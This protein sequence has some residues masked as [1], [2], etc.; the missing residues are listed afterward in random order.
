MP[1]CA[2]CG[3]ELPEGARFCPACAAPVEPSPAVEER[4][5]ATVLFADLVGSTELGGSQDP[6]RTRALLNRFYDAMAE[7]IEQAGGTVE[8]FA[9][10][11]VM[12]AF[13]AP[14]AHED[15][16]ERALHTA[17]SMQR[18]LEELFAGELDLRIGINTGEVVVGRP[19]EGSSFVTGDAVNVAARLEQA[20]TSGEILAGERTVAAVS[21]AFE[22][23]EPTTVEAKGKPG[24]VDCRR[25]VRALSL[26][27]PRGVGGLRSAFLGR[28]NELEVLQATYRR[29]AG[30]GEPHLVTIMGDAGV[31][32]TRLVRELWTWLAGEAPQPLQR[33]GRC[34]PYGQV[35]YWALGEVLKEHLG[36]LESDAPEAARKRLGSREILGLALGLDVG[37]DLH[38][39]AAR[40]RL[41]EAWIEFLG[42]LVAEQPAVLLV[43]DLH[44]ADEELLDL[45][46]RMVREVHGPLFVVGTARPELLDRRPAWSG[47]RRNATVLW[48]EP[49]SP[50]HS[51]QMVEELLAAELPRRLRE[52]VVDRAEGN[53]F[54]VEELVATLIDQGVL[55]QTDGR[56]SAGELPAGFEIP[57][58]VHAVL[59][60]RIDLLGAADKAGLQAASVIGR[61]FWPGP[62]S[63]LV[64]GSEPDWAALEDRDFVR[65]RAGSSIAGEVEYAFKHT[66]T[67]EVAYGSLPKAQRARL[68]AAFADWL[69]QYGE[70]RDEHAPLL[71]HHYAEATRP[72]DADLAWTGRENEHEQ[73]R[74]KA[75]AWLHRAADLAVGRYEL[76]EALGLLHRALE[77][78]ERRAGR[79]EM[80][81]AIGRANAF[82]FDGE[83]FWTAM[84]QAIELCEDRRLTAELYSDLALE[85]L[86]RSGM[87]RRRPD[88][89]VVENWIERALELAEPGSKARARG[90]IARSLLEEVG[91][92]P[93]A[94]E[95]TELAEQLGDPELRVLAWIA[96]ADAAFSGGDYDGALGWASRAF[97]IVDEIRDPD[98]RAD[99][100]WM[101][102][103]PAVGRGRLR[104]GRRLA[105]AYDE[106]NAGLTPH[107]RVHGVAVLLEVEELGGG[108]GRVQELEARAEETIGKN[109]ETPCIRNPRSLLL[110]ALARLYD[111][112]EAE[113]R[114]L[115]E[116]ADDLGME[117]F[118]MILDGPR[119][120][121]A[122]ARGDLARVEQ[123]LAE[124]S[125]PSSIHT[126]FFLNS[127]A[128]WLDGLAAIGDR[129]RVEADALPLLK[130]N[131]YLEP[132]ALRALGFVREDES[133][134]EQAV[135]RF[136][137]MRLDWHA[138]E[139]RKLFA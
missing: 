90:L 127:T 38:P 117:G 104:E 12:A 48:L 70:G 64:G 17:L 72:Q 62:V 39:L 3:A 126:T 136:E 4:K 33:T 125:K 30:Q 108:W 102:I 107:H 6:E 26:M 55:Q 105:R 46:E 77:L 133:L 51:A 67:R 79:A 81:H 37:G 15:H 61:T 87:W 76:D 10:D 92:A 98:L 93:I 94:A 11:A 115:E 73:L 60:A 59:A 13:G 85:T 49:L 132:F 53:P 9:G 57:D 113:A 28:D 119:L 122:L 130:P 121:L 89:S 31:G 131:T 52:V 23:G 32:K 83:A 138:A 35:T 71:A 50:E 88:D 116:Q 42:E 22:F 106:A 134:L 21:G 84:Q 47:G 129:Q 44:W 5:L 80:W 137:A 16:A 91:S 2:Q 45:L 68:H 103:L 99:I 14:D 118:G 19:R 120:R 25:V 20:A 36:I 97:E 1:A 139:T 66:L 82:K 41:H 109:L 56:W 58:S 18:R 101:P 123:L 54:F 135:N 124:T 78:E 63:E 111:G 43:E 100:C 29:V 8:K 7:E 128:I 96:H 110:C 75:L 27:R 74:A 86:G 69:E 65:R 24:G 114:R 95:A 40:N 112:E 34:L